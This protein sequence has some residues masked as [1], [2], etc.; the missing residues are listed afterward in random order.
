MKEQN[1]QEIRTKESHVALGKANKIRGFYAFGGETK[2]NW[3]ECRNVGT[4]VQ[5]ILVQS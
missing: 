3:V 4:A 5:L 2:R 1:K